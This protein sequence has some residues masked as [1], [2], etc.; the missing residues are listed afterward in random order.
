MHLRYIA[1]RRIV[2]LHSHRVSRAQAVVVRE[3]ENAV[4]ALDEL[5]DDA[6]V[7]VLNL[8]PRDALPHIPGYIAWL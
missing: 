2:A 3:S 8:L 7:K 6:V 4:L 5:A 1:P